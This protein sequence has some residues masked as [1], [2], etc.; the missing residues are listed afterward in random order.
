MILLLWFVFMIQV[1]TG[2]RHNATLEPAAGV[3]NLDRFL[4]FGRIMKSTGAEERFYCWCRQ[5][6]NHR[7][8]R[9]IDKK[10]WQCVMRKNGHYRIEELLDSEYTLDTRISMLMNNT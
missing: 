9:R 5:D 3:P 8:S 4:C 6:H 10:G 1:A 7:F 2:I